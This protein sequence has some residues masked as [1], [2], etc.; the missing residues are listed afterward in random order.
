VC[1]KPPST[2]SPQFLELKPLTEELLPAVVALD[3]T[4]F[5]GLWTLDGY[6][7][8][9]ES[10]NSEILVLP[11]PV[12]KNEVRGMKAESDIQLIGMGCFWAILE[13]AHITILAVHPNFQR[14]G[15]GQWILCALL[16]KACDRGLERA[17]L[18]V[19]ISNQVA[20]TLYQKFGFREAGRRRRY[21]QDTG[22]DALILWRNGLQMQNF[23][24]ELQAWQE[25]VAA[26]LQQA[27]WHFRCIS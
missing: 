1:S 6:Q 21:Y 26:R 12:L 4:C 3:Q 9:L 7:R 13:E 23:Q 15:L 10:P 19:R 18:E 14:Q 5:G 17:T 27:G 11:H 24:H 22:E 16:Q 8:E 20:L 25:E 2:A